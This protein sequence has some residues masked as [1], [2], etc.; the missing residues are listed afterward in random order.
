MINLLPP[1]HKEYIYYGRKNYQTL[2]WL[3]TVAFGVG[4]LL[5]VALVGRLTIQTAR[6]QT[7]NQKIAVEAQISDA[8]LD[9]T[10]KEYTS[11]VEG[12]DNV[13]KVYQQQI[14]YS[15]LIR[16]LATLLPP[17]SSLTNIS[18]SDK[19]RAVNLDFNNDRDGLGPTIQINLENQGDQIAEKSRIMTERAF[20]IPLAGQATVLADGSNGSLISIDS[21]TRQ[22]DYFVNSP[23]NDNLTVFRNAL[24]NGGE[25]A[26]ELAYPSLV[27]KGVTNEKSL[28]SIP[29]LLSYTVNNDSKRVD[30]YFNANSID[31]VKDIANT[32]SNQP[33]TTFIETYTFNDDNYTNAEKCTDTKT[34]KKT[35]SMVCA[36]NQNDCETSSK[37]CVPL[38]DRGCRYVVRSYYDELYTSSSII[39]ASKEEKVLCE[40]N[41]G[42]KCTHKVSAQYSQL[43]DKVDINRVASCATDEKTS[44]ISCP[45]QVRAKFDSNA[46]FY[47]INGIGATQ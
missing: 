40:K 35:C 43:F 45:V 9:A 3:T 23:E 25:Y 46:K 16:K 10:E 8:N 31:Q 28:V 39:P 4:I 37:T 27:A 29:H 34:N 17:G 47:L 20:G 13:K 5:V 1:D 18:L 26:Y 19:D 7:L 44:K 30:Y 12:I 33:Y 15:R 24:K 2:I 21:K 32:I 6:N 38:Q 14:L 41:S 36:D 11:F 22:L 42:K